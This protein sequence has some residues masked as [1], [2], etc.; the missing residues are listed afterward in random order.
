MTEDLFTREPDFTYTEEDAV[1]DGAAIDMGGY[2]Y[3]TFRGEPVRTVSDTLFA[4]LQNAFRF[5]ATA[6]LPMT[7]EIYQAE[8]D[9]MEGEN[10]RDPEY[11][12][13]LRGQNLT[14]LFGIAAIVPP[15][16]VLGELLQAFIAGAADTA[17][18]GEPQ[19]HL[20]ATRPVKALRNRA[21]WLQRPK[22]GEWTAFFPEDY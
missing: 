19:D 22:A 11:V 7:P 12:S 18:P 20:Y 13:W 4:A 6:G 14:D 16:A 21:V 15:W 8:L 10:G 1:D 9:S 17:E 3:A 5:A 2:G